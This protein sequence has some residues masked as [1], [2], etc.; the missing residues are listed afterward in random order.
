VHPCPCSAGAARAD[1]EFGEF[2]GSGLRARLGDTSP[3]GKGRGKRGRKGGG[4]KGKGETRLWVKMRAASNSPIVIVVQLNRFRIS[5][6]ISN[7]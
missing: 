5:M 6:F 3:G 4:R 1:G 7:M 2:D